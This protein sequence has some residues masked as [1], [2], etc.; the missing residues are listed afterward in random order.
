MRCTG[1]INYLTILVMPIDNEL[2]EFSF[3]IIIIHNCSRIL[4]HLL[5]MYD[6]LK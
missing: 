3:I 6:K 2:W 5:K 4:K 1:A